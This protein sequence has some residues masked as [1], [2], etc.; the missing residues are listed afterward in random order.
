MGHSSTLQP[1]LW[2][3]QESSLYVYRKVSLQMEYCGSNMVR[4]FWSQKPELQLNI[5]SLNKI[6]NKVII[7][8]THAPLAFYRFTAM[9][10][11]V[12]HFPTSVNTKVTCPPESC[13]KTEKIIKSSG[14]SSY[15]SNPTKVSHE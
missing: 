6:F 3:G 5:I 8:S 12:V 2:H 4:M 7:R 14:P 11:F 9:V 1:L 15:P 13:P 10:E